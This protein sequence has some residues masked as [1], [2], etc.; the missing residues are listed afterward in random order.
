MEKKTFTV[1]IVDDEV[2]ITEVLGK[3][4]NMEGYDVLVANNGNDALSLAKERYPEVVLL[5]MRM[6][7]MGSIE[8]LKRLKKI[9]EDCVVIIVSAVDDMDIALSV[10]KEGANE[11]IRK[12]VNLQELKLSIES[13]LEKRRLIIENR[14]YQKRLEEKVA[15]KTAELRGMYLALKKTNLEIVRALAEAI[16][17]KDPYTRGH[18]HRVTQFSL[19]LGKEVGLSGEQLESLEY[20][21]LL[22]D[23]GKIGIRGAVLNKDGK[24]TDEEY[25]HIKTH[26]AIGDR[27]LENIDFL[28][29]P[30]QIVK[31]H[32]ER[33]DGKG[34]PNQL[35]K[36]QMDIMSQ[37]VSIA[38]AYDAMTSDRPYRKGM[39]RVRALE[40][41]KENEGSQFNQELAEIFIAKK[42]F[43]LDE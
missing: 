43:L 12:P 20:G 22:H 35:G 39:S 40:I 17:A 7:G 28:K 10:V 36:W 4:M 42:L 18:C 34:Y 15:E 11:F 32:H 13:N 21:G 16:E 26:P 33:F 9:N 29:E 23:I 30:R 6:P 24:L 14:V 19:K 31:G 25:D 41:M 38:D 37:I 1:L 8:V 2:K 3:F 27:I 5:D